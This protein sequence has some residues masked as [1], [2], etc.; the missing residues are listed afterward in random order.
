MSVNQHRITASQLISQQASRALDPV[1]GPQE[2][3]EGPMAR[4]DAGSERMDFLEE[5]LERRQAVKADL[6]IVREVTQ[7]ACLGY[8]I[9]ELQLPALFGESNGKDD[10]AH[11][12]SPHSGCAE[13][14][15]EGGVAGQHVLITLLD[16]QLATDGRDVSQR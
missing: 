5:R 4:E 14:V 12:D 9:F 8:A 15:C 2:D 13:N 10:E 7:P 1:Q 11:D 3:V 6:T 16:G